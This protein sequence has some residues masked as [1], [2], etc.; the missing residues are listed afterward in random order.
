MAQGSIRDFDHD[1]QTA[2]D[3]GIATQA[4]ALHDHHVGCGE[5]LVQRQ[6]RIVHELDVGMLPG[7]V[8]IEFKPLGRVQADDARDDRAQR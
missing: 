2:F 7:D 3:Q 5:R 1:D 8:G 4:A 6:L